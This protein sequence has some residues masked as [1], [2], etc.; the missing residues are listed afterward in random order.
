MKLRQGLREHR[1]LL[2]ALA[3]IAPLMLV[4]SWSRVIG[5]LG[6][7]APDYMIM[8]RYYAAP[9]SPD[10]ADR[11]FASVS[12][13][14]PLY[15]MLLAVL[16]GSQDLLRAHLITTACLLLGLVVFA[17]WLTRQGVT[18]AA[19]ALLT[20][21]FAM[22][23]NTW[24]MGLRPQS[25][26]L[27]LLLSLTAL[28]LLA[29]HERNRQADTLLT[30][31]LL[32]AAA[33]LERTIGVT[34]LA[35]LAWVAWRERRLRG[36]PTVALAAAPLLAWHFLHRARLGYNKS[37]AVT[38]GE[39][40]LASLI[41][42]VPELFEVYWTGFRHSF[43]P[44]ALPPALASAIAATGALAAVWRLLRLRPDAIYLCAYGPVLLIWP[45]PEEAERLLWPV[46]PILLAQPLL[47]IAEMNSAGARRDAAVQAYAACLAVSIM[48]MALPSIARAAD[49][50]RAASFW[51]MLADA[52]H[53]EGWY[54]PDLAYAVDRVVGQL[55]T[56]E[57]LAE[58]PR[59]A[60]A[61]DCVAA[62]R[63][64]FVTYVARRRSVFPPLNSVPDPWFMRI[65]RET[66]CHYVFMYGGTGSQFPVPF[67]PLQRLPQPIDMLVDHRHP[68]PPPGEGTMIGLLARIP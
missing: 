56:M 12:R 49:R 44:A 26:Y 19:A 52:R 29:R 3:V 51:P 35:P 27:Y 38:Y 14:P 41:Q 9:L 45:F 1:W 66:G 48:A 21:L 20:L 42:R 11:D 32:V 31:A 18:G 47:V 60:P 28:L 22:L 50:Y 7:D 62:A 58:I 64:N 54:H 6:S 46:L 30:A 33:S 53:Y 24:M 17:L 63:P 23:P 37:I 65:L 39:H 43:L 68:D 8:A 67:H 16:G 10:A 34:L 57:A 13:F 5:E 15:P 25:E 61:D 4:W 2:M 40:P 59:F 36:L 55:G